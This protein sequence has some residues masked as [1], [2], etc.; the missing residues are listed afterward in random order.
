[1]KSLITIFAI[2]G[3]GTTVAL[4]EDAPAADNACAAEAP[5]EAPADCSKLEGEEKEKCEAAAKTD[6]AAEAPAEGKSGKSMQKSD[7]GNMEKFD[8]DE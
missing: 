5:A 1:M 6:E 3:L 2:L 7:D 8:E 4:A